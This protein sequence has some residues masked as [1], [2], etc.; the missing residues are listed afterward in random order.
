MIED[1]GSPQKEGGF[2]LL[3]VIIAMTIM[4][5]AF[6]SILSVLSGGITAAEKTHQVNIVAMLARNKMTEVEYDIEGKNFDEVK[7]EDGGAFGAPYEDFR[8]ETAVKEVKFPSLN[9]GGGG[10]GGDNKGGAQP[11]SDLVTLMTKLITN[12]LS[13]SVREVD[14]T[15][16]WKR[17]SGEQSFV[18]STFWVDLNHEFELQP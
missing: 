13:K 14:V 5:L 8:W 12:F 2:T 4:I 7:K 17:P 1:A 9:F 10:P 3:E 16:F 15:I 18:V 11:V 6:S